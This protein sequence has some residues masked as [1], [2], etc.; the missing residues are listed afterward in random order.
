LVWNEPDNKHCACGIA[1]NTDACSVL[2]CDGFDD[3]QAQ[4]A[5]WVSVGVAPAVE[6]GEDVGHIIF[7]NSDTGISNG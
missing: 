7:W 1:I 4:S 3:G 5:I 2:V 6:A